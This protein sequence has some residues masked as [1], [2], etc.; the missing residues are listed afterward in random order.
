L[1]RKTFDIY[2]IFNI[3][4]TLNIRKALDLRKTLNIRKILLPLD[5]CSRTHG[6]SRVREDKA[7][8]PVLDVEEVTVLLSTNVKGLRILFSKDLYIYLIKED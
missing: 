1:L 5:G 3:Y 6:A 2:T 7:G 4:R 8:R